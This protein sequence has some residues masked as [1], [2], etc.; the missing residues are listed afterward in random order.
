MDLEI[1]LDL[2][3]RILVGFGWEMN[4]ILFGFYCL[5]LEYKNQ[6][7]LLLRAIWVLSSTWFGILL[8]IGVEICFFCFCFCFC[9]FVF[10]F[11]FLEAPTICLSLLKLANYILFCLEW[12]ASIWLVFKFCSVQNKI[13][14]QTIRKPT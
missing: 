8:G 2:G 6:T 13:S 3:V 14:S 4:F 1:W 5:N 10:V 7:I 12:C 11:L 9:F